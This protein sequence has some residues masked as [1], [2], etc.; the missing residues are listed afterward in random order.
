MCN[1][2]LILIWLQSLGERNRKDM[3]SS[4]T[5]GMGMVPRVPVALSK[6]KRHADRD[7]LERSRF[8]E[9]MLLMCLLVTVRLGQSTRDVDIDSF[10]RLVVVSVELLY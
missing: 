4:D 7:N 3:S 10:T 2:I 9:V 6:L 1:S 8:L 5:L